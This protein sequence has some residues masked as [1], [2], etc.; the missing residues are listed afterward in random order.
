MHA[1]DTR[2]RVQPIASVAVASFVATTI[3]TTSGFS[4]SL[5]ESGMVSTRSSRYVNISTQYITTLNEITR[6]AQRVKTIS[7]KEIDEDEDLSESEKD[8]LKE[9]NSKGVVKEKFGS[10]TV[11]VDLSQSWERDG[12]TRQT[13]AR[14][15]M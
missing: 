2:R 12:G 6:S 10:W 3:S 14:N 7:Y 11:R 9:E 4:S 5:L 8:L 1:S 15:E 13:F